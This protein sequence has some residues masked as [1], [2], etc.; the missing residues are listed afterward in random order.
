VRGET[1]IEVWQ[2]K[3]RLFRK[4][5]KGWSANIEAGNRRIKDR[6]SVE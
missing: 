4:K 2:S 5:I 6:L 1:A 3:V